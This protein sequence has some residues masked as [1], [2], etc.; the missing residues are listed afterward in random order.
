MRHFASRPTWIRPSLRSTRLI[1]CVRMSSADRRVLELRLRLWFG[2]LMFVSTCLTLLSAWVDLSKEINHIRA[3]EVDLFLLGNL[4]NLRLEVLE[5][6]CSL[7]SFYD[8]HLVFNV[9]NGLVQMFGILSTLHA[10]F[11]WMLVDFR[12]SFLDLLPIQLLITLLLPMMSEL[13]ILQRHYSQFHWIMSLRDQIS[14]LYNHRNL[15]RLM[16]QLRSFWI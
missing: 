8:L 11:R 10:K 15:I 13:L 14:I 12:I 2:P 5:R 6:I 1:W 3:F 9:L 4:L 7:L 16:L